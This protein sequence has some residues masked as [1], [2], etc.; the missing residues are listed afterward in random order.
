M[1]AMPSAEGKRARAFITKLENVKNMPPTNADPS[2]AA[3][4]ITGMSWSIPG[5]R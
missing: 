2:R 3:V 4:P 5:L 1:A